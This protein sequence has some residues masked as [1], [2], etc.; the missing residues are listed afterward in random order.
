MGIWEWIERCGLRFQ[1]LRTG[2]EL[3]GQDGF[4]VLH[5]ADLEIKSKEVRDSLMQRSWYLTGMFANF[6]TAL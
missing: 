2:M 6:G 5:S 1:E 4:L 3:M